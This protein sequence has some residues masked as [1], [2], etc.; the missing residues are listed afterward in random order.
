MA[1]PG[2][3]GTEEAEATRTARGLTQATGYASMTTVTIMDLKTALEKNPVPGL[4]YRTAA[5]WVSQGLVVAEGGGLQGHELDIGPKQL[6]ELRTLAA[7]R[8]VLSLQALKKAA[9]VLRAMGYNPFS[10]GHFAV[11][12]GGELV[13]LVNEE[14]A[15]A[16]IRQPGQV[17]AVVRLSE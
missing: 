10:T 4:T 11:V 17:C 14:E 5:R 6:H 2:V 12:E 15:V 1:Q 8:Q 3:V 9:S 7:L 16:L 13:R